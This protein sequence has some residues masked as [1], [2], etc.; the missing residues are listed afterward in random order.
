M[1]IENEENASED[2]LDSLDEYQLATSPHSGRN[3]KTT[4]FV[5]D[6]RQHY[7]PDS[8]SGDNSSDL[9]EVL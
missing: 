8:C 1:H 9:D 4:L 2:T 7:I 5:V 3:K 6:V